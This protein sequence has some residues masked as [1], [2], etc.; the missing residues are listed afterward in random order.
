MSLVNDAA[1]RINAG[2]DGNCRSQLDA[3]KESHYALLM[4]PPE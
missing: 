4:E 1:G 3:D 2:G